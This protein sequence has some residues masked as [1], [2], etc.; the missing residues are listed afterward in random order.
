MLVEE[1]VVFLL[2]GAVLR[3]V[4]AQAVLVEVEMLVYLTAL[5]NQVLLAHLILVVVVEGHQQTQAIMAAL[6]AQA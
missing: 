6:V 2:A 3:L 1:E 4:V 5:Q